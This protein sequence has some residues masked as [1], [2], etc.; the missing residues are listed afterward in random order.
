MTWAEAGST[1]SRSSGRRSAATCIWSA[2]PLNRNNNTYINQRNN[3]NNL[4]SLS[5]Y[6]YIYI[7][8][9]IRV[10]VCPRVC[11]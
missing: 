11:V 9:H 4:I 7:Y 2:A 8:I 5:L 6:V 10:C 3:I 1:R